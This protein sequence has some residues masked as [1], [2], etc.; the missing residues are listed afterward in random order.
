MRHRGWYLGI[1]GAVLLAIGLFALRFPVFLDH[2]DQWG[3]QVRC[4]SGFVADLAQARDAT[5]VDGTDFVGDCESALLIRRAWTVPLVVA[6]ALAV[7]AV[8][9]VAAFTSRDEPLV[10]GRDRA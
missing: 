1:G 7:M 3:W 4:G 5:S 6:G 9:A 2:Y 8:M 10:G